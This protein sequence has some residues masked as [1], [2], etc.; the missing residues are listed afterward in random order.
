MFLMDEYVVCVLDALSQHLELPFK[1][2]AQWIMKRTEV[3]KR[4][5][6]GKRS[7]KS[8]PEDW[9]QKEQNV[10]VHDLVLPI[11]MRSRLIFISLWL[12]SAHCG[13]VIDQPIEQGVKRGR[14]AFDLDASASEDASLL[15]GLGR[16]K[17][18]RTESGKRLMPDREKRILMSEQS[19]SDSEDNSSTDY[20]SDYEDHAISINDSDSDSEFNFREK[21]LSAQYESH[22]EQPNPD[23]VMRSIVFGRLIERIKEQEFLTPEI[24]TQLRLNWANNY[25][26]V[27]SLYDDWMPVLTLQ[28][29]IINDFDPIIT[30][31][32]NRAQ[33]I[34][35]ASNVVREVQS[36][37]NQLIKLRLFELGNY[38]SSALYSQRVASLG[39]YFQIPQGL[40]DQNLRLDPKKKLEYVGASLLDGVKQLTTRFD[41]K[42]ELSR[43]TLNHSPTRWVLPWS[44]AFRVVDLLANTG[45]INH[46]QLKSFFQ[47]EEMIKQVTLYSN[48][49]LAEM[50]EIPNELVWVH[51]NKSFKAL[52]TK[53][54]ASIQ[55]SFSEQKRSK[56]H[57]S[58]PSG[59]TYASDDAD[60]KKIHI[61]VDQKMEQEYGSHRLSRKKDRLTSSQSFEAMLRS[62]IIRKLQKEVLEQKR[63]VEKEFEQL[64][65]VRSSI[66]PTAPVNLDSLVTL[67]LRH[68]LEDVFNEEKTALQQGMSLEQDLER[69]LKRARITDPQN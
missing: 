66:V 18:P 10:P 43:W 29:W 61:L 3:L 25:E 59:I 15:D 6:G 63:G 5:A 64:L 1:V 62:R 19:T 30:L 67:T 42:K 55:S 60:Q 34:W 50:L 8:I 53:T 26:Q 16:Q 14:Q 54:R 46:D 39:S 49:I 33:N 13:G 56:A 45:F 21:H 2:Q 4:E 28:S 20:G 48:A 44:Y 47:G 12:F 23:P 31:R 22:N 69:Q 37:I 9:H 11:I 27:K 68:R 65:D 51:L 40:T 35:M 52:D 38:D 7:G 24:I 58:K 17:Q 36:K 41:L 57:T 32:Q